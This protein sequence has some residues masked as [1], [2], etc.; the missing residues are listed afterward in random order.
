MSTSKQDR[1]PK[2]E[3][4]ENGN[5][6]NIEQLITFSELGKAITGSFEL[7][8]ILSTVM[9]KIS[10]LFHSKEW[11]LLTVDEENEELRYET[12]LGDEFEKFKDIR[13][14][15]GEG[16]AGWVAKEGVP[17]IV[18]DVTADERFAEHKSKLY[19]FVTG[20]II[21]VPLQTKGKMVGVIELYN[22]DVARFNNKENFLL[23]TTLADYTAIAIE[24]AMLFK[25]VEDLTIIDDLT[26]L[27]NSRFF[28][29]SLEYEV[30]KAKRYETPITLIFI[31]L[32]YFKQ[33]NDTHDHLCGSKLLKEIGRIIGKAIRSVDIG[34]RYGGD[35]FVILLPEAEKKHG[36]M[37]AERIRSR[38]NA[39]TFLQDEG[40]NC[41][42]SASFGVGT[43]PDDASNKQE[44]ID[45]TD[46]AMY[47]VKN[48]A[49]D[50][51]LA[52]EST[53]ESEAP[54]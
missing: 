24:N 52:Y 54:K 14:K 44:L 5:N 41:N 19:D 34:C 1:F 6:G 2:E 10:V 13:P 42:M 43:L 30:E 9:E 53:K 39:T 22:V 3:S 16:I 38:I 31:D 7:K 15:L 45:V 28:Y 32:D 51:V 17:L 35:E 37:V 21:S 33:I 26:R 18:E 25:K 29:H 48:D 46:Q 27:Y 40:I 49:R 47:R 23:L 36:I 12:V 50:G 8:D 11:S 20:G 4:A